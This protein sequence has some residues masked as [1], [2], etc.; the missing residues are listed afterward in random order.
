MTARSS[1]LWRLALCLAA[2]HNYSAS[3]K[4]PMR[5]PRMKARRGGRS[6]FERWRERKVSGERSILHYQ[7]QASPLCISTPSKSHK[8]LRTH[9]AT[10]GTLV[11]FLWLTP[12]PTS[13]VKQ[14]KTRISLRSFNLP[15]HRT[16][17]VHYQ[18]PLPA[19][20]FDN[21]LTSHRPGFPRSNA[22]SARRVLSEAKFRMHIY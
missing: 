15:I 2:T 4:L 11:V 13:H 14:P 16:Q 3:D 17:W 21:L 10:V 22:T 5:G 12:P 1:L 7:R 8:S 18:L 19:W 20:L 9:R 6:K